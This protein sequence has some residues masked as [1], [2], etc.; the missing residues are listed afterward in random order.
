MERKVKLGDL[1]LAKDTGSIHEVH[2]IWPQGAS[3]FVDFGARRLEPMGNDRHGNSI[4][5]G[6][7]FSYSNDNWEFYDG[8]ETYVG[9]KAKR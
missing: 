6:R 4:P 7:G 3:K 9:S 2:A 8:G 1:I 5:S